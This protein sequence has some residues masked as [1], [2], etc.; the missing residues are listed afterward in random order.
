MNQLQIINPHFINFKDELLTIDVLGGVD[1]Q[2]V[3]RMICTLRVSH[4]NYPPFRTTL[5]LYND[6]QN[7]KLIRTLCDKYELQLL[8]VSKALNLLTSQLEEYRLDNLK[9]N[10]TSQKRAFEINEEERANAIKKLKNK[11]LLTLLI[12]DLNTTG[13]IGEDE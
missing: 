3:E 8:E 9:Y 2:Q 12:K 10:S 7:D 11:N 4:A 5:D 13:I 1:L 6:S